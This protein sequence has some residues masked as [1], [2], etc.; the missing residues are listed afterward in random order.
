MVQ[1]PVPERGPGA[2]PGHDGGL[3]GGMPGA[4]GV[5]DTARG[6]RDLRLAD[7]AE[8]G[9]GDTSPPGAG[10]GAALEELSG[11]GWHCDGATDDELIGLLGRWAAME[12]R[13]AAGK[14]GVVR[15]LIRR[16]GLPG[17]GKQMHGDLPDAWDEG[18]GHEVSGA[19]RI[20][21]PAADKLIDLAWTLQARLPGIGAKLADGTT[22]YVRAK[23]IAEETAVLDDEQVAQA[24]ALI[25]KQMAGKTPA[26]V[27]KL[28]VRAVITVDPD[29]ARKRRE[30]AERDEARVRFWRER[31]G[32]SAL[33]AYGLPTDAALAAN[34]NVNQRAQEYKQARID[35][36]MDQLRVLAFLDI[37][38]GTSAA[39]RIAQAQA[40][41][42]TQPQA[43]ERGCGSEDRNDDGP[44]GEGPQGAG[45]SGPADGDA[46]GGPADGDA[47]RG[48]ADGDAPG[49]P[50]DGDGPGG[51][52]DGDA[53]GGPAAGDGSGGPAD[54]DGP[55]GPAAGD[56]PGD[57][58]RTSPDTDHANP[59]L[60]ARSNLTIPLSTLLG[61][62]DRPGEGHGLGPLD[63]ALARDLA[64]AASRS[65]HSEWC[66]TVTDA[67]GVAIGHGCAKPA[68]TRRAKSPPLS[69]RN[70]PWAFTA[71][72][73]PGPPGGFGTWT[74]ALPDGRELIVK[75]GPIPVAEC[76][77]RY[78]SHAYQPS[79]TLRHL[80]QI[81]DGECTFPSCSR[82][83]RES[84]FE[85]A[86]PYDKGG[87]TCMCNAGARS[88]RCHK[89][90]QSKGWSLTQ[91]RPGWHQW[92]AP[93]GRTYT[94]G[95]MQYPI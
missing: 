14:L 65:P 66:V 47:P 70:G 84:D 87:R 78:E 11:P 31:T 61:L 68:R 7:F 72:D 23:I 3:S 48:P 93:S 95:P 60:P 22:D 27:K 52:A 50:A 51:P 44:S 69:D 83:A 38:N 71:R 58:P 25:L 4:S 92:T 12:S 49:G 73:D 28:A 15:A 76:N 19:L 8:G 26:Q 80:V 57:G 21:L 36:T 63:P 37:L 94:Q 42:Q 32:A 74:L 89:V 82:H 56:G 30:Q 88:R 85:H 1:P 55:G 41:A 77:H 64:A 2:E 9:A 24:E 5:P 18:A 33:A 45:P 43:A 75:L 35:G 10:L 54:G 79:E 16:R 13:A 29:G 46:P 6:C 62:A 91:P 17:L 53:P 86:T 67:N 90:K 59:G 40:Q 34:A 20:S 81:R 39:A